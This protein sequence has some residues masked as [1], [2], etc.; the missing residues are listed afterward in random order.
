[1]ADS[2]PIHSKLRL[3]GAEFRVREKVNP[4]SE[5]FEAVVN[6]PHL[7]CKFMT[8]KLISIKS[9]HIK[10][11]FV[12]VVVVIVVVVVFLWLLS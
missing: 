2:Q 3:T 9:Q 11:L 4:S 5:R 8:I 7:L 1:M 10:A 6:L 12:V